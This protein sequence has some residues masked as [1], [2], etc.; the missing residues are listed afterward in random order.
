VPKLTAQQLKEHN[1]RLVLK[2]IYSGQAASR[3]ALA[4]E[5]GLTRP[6]VSQ[7]VAELLELGLVHEAGPGES[8]G[9]KPPMLLNFSDDVYEI[10]GLHV[11]A[12]RTFGVVTDLRGRIAARAARPTD[13]TDDESV[14]VGLYFVLD[15][16]RARATRPVL[17]IGVSAP[18]IVDHR[19]GIVRYSTHLKWQDLPLSDRLSEHCRDAVPIFVDNDT[20]LAA[21]GERVF[22]VGGGV[23]NMVIVM[24]GTR[25]IGAGLILNG[26]IYHGTEGGA[27]EIGHVPIVDNGV[28]CLC[29]RQG[30]L[31]A[32][33]SGWALVR[34]AQDIGVTYPDSILTTGR[35]NGTS[36]EDV[37]QAVAAGDPAAEALAHEAGR[38][39]GFAVAALIS[40][41]N[42]RRVVVGGSVSELGAPFFESLNCT[43]Q[44]QT[45][46]LLVEKTEI[47][48]ASLG[49]DVNLL[50]AVAQVLDQ[51]L[52]VV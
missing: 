2:A 38:Y 30:C 10:I 47:L 42:P 24:A 37:Q 40:T 15:E 45:L 3:A 41:L 1:Q 20:N 21:L 29:G 5:T 50:G 34:R 35:T 7:I 48:P 12:R 36:F 52:G 33:A 26:E 44:T 43:I 31:E 4:Q 13:R 39:L 17:G 16:L 49:A 8:S 14:L 32:V 18:G 51:E 46:G 19:H 27:G 11:G 23:D 22:G 28:P 25:G 9:G 6:T